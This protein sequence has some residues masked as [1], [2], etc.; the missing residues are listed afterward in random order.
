MNTG[1]YVTSQSKEHGWLAC[2][3]VGEETGNRIQAM[4]LASSVDEIHEMDIVESL[5]CLCEPALGSLTNRVHH[6]YI[7]NCVN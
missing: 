4:N 2:L 3:A 1:I 7:G 6:R 5:D